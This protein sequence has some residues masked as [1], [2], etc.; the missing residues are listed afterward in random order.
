[1]DIHDT[2]RKTELKVTLPRVKI[3]RLFTKQGHA[4]HLSAEDVYKVL[5][6]QGENIGLATVYRVLTQF[7][8]VGLVVRHHFVDDCAVYELASHEHHDHLICT[9][10]GKVTE[11]VDETIENQQQKVAK[12]AEFNMTHHSLN[13]YGVCA[14]C[15][16]LL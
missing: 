6:E 9:K 14:K 7:E 5:I 10:C 8:A 1:M 4:R 15:Q 3:L 12:K 11:F 16:S 13:I 2:L